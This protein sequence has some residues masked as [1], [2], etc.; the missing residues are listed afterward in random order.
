M[1]LEHFPRAL[2]Q[3][4]YFLCPLTRI[5]HFPQI[6]LTIVPD[7]KYVNILSDF[8]IH[9]TFSD[10]KMS[11]PE[12][13]DF[14]GIRGFG[15]I[16]ITDHLCEQST[17]LGKASAYLNCTLTEAT[18]P[19]YLKILESEAMRAW[20]QYRML[21]IPGVEITKNSISNHR[22]AHVLALGVTKW[23]S[24]D[25][26]ISNVLDEIHAQGALT[27]A[28]HPVWTRF[29]EKQTFHLWSRRS[30]LASKFDA[31]EVASGPHL[32]NEVEKERLPLIANSDL[33]RPEQ[34]HSWKTV[35][36]GERK[37]EAVLEN[38]KKQNLSFTFYKEANIN[39]V[40]SHPVRVSLGALDWNALGW[41]VLGA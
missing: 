22:S 4:P 2:L 30:E 29:M 34:I 37:T 23:I 3:H 31:W 36:H 24:A 35:V 5:K 12:I 21:L 11:I 16:A 26:D 7:N 28:A 25:G 32:F 33:H 13:V 39:V 27:I 15:A 1:G 38:I 6:V 18:F 17:F 19:I 41:N 10:G 8:H 9:S 20:D 14:Y 40:P